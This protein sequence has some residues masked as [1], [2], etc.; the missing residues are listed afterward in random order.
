MNAGTRRH[1]IA[2]PAGA[3][4][5]A[6]DEPPPARRCAAWR[7]CAT[8][9]RCTAARWT[10]RSCRRWPGRWCS[11]AFARCAST[12][13]A[14]GIGRHWDQG[15]GEVDDALAVL[16]HWRDAALPLALGGFSFGGYVATQAAARLPEG[17]K[18]T[19]LVLVA[20]AVVNFDA[21]PVPQDS[22]VIHGEADEVVPL[23]AVLDWARPQVLPVTVVP[24]TGHFFHGQL[25]LLKQLVVN[26]WG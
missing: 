13:A 3:I 4:E 19:R 7:C 10:T 23:Q 12:S 24:A 16:A 17:A 22:L 2:G 26:G 25:T 18:A 14:S 1:A 11:A 21:A 5:C 15:P 9:T 8:R 20:P 6:V